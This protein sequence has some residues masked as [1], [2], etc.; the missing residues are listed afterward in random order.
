MHFS[1]YFPWYTLMF[2]LIY[3]ATP[4]SLLLTKILGSHVWGLP[5]GENY[6][7]V[8]ALLNICTF[9]CNNMLPWA[10]ARLI[11]IFVYIIFIF[12]LQCPTWASIAYKPIRHPPVLGG[13]DKEKNT[14]GKNATSLHD[15]I[16]NRKHD[17]MKTIPIDERWSL[18]FNQV[19]LVTSP[20]FM[21]NFTCRSQQ[22]V[23]LFATFRSLWRCVF[24]GGSST[25]HV[26]GFPLNQAALVQGLGR[27]MMQLIPQHL[28]LANGF[29][30]LRGPTK[31]HPVEGWI[32]LGKAYGNVYD[33]FL[34][35]DP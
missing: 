24:W 35:G 18:F 3:F 29:I 16:P 2:F 30:P 34:V 23:L 7:P 26:E 25:S 21:L 31:I 13:I 19:K 5:S 9:I 27:T 20:I 6:N 22:F 4:F 12:L 33:K 17:T 14:R 10:G 8:Y 28:L 1:A 32:A 15:K 11:L